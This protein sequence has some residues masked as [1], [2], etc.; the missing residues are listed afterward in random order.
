MAQRTIYGQPQPM[1]PGNG[2]PLEALMGQ[3]G[4]SV[5]SVLN[6]KNA[7]RSIYGQSQDALLRGQS[8]EA[9]QLALKAKQLDPAVNSPHYLPNPTA[10]QQLREDI[11]NG[12]GIGPRGP[13]D[14]R[15]AQ[16]PPDN[17]PMAENVMLGL[18]IDP[19]AAQRMAGG[20]SRF[21]M[22]ALPPG[23]IPRKG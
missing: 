10:G 11:V 14:P 23:I 3:P 4:L 20:A 2:L 13:A 12:L 7:A 5:Q 16:L 15:E 9:G 8:V 19:A 17:T 22:G 18:G 21:V 1:V 6:A